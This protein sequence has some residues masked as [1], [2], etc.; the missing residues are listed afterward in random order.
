VSSVTTGG[1]GGHQRVTF[2][3]VAQFVQGA[4]GA[5]GTGGVIATPYTQWTP[6]VV[7]KFL[8]GSAAVSTILASDIT[9]GAMT[10]GGQIA[11]VTINGQPVI[12][13]RA[14]V[15]TT[16]ATPVEPAPRQL[17]DPF[18]F[19]A[20]LGGGAPLFQ[21]GFAYDGVE[22]TAPST[23]LPPKSF[24]QPMIGK[25]AS[26][27]FANLEIYLCGVYQGWLSLAGAA[28]LT[29]YARGTYAL[30]NF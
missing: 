6:F 7:G 28:R 26:G 1:P 27:S 13:H 2:D 5:F 9:A 14:F 23:V 17:T 15:S 29:D 4:T 30:A 16:I 21:G 8:S 19:F 11:T 10:I 3:G 12:Q 20:R 18:V 22:G 25:Q 24:I